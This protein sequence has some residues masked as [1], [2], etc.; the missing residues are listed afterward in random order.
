MKQWCAKLDKYAPFI[1]SCAAVVSALMAYAAWTFSRE[2]SKPAPALEDMGVEYVQ[3][4]SH[5]I[6]IKLRFA[7][8]NIG[9]QFL[10]VTHLG[11]GKV[12]FHTNTYQQP[13]V[14][15][16]ADDK[17]RNHG[18]KSIFEEFACQGRCSASYLP[19]EYKLGE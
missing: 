10:E 12:D 4:D 9:K 15:I 6:E 8:R 14:K 2:L 5:T 17:G 7:L 16:Y 13:A 1:A 3:V 19:A 11:A 18:S